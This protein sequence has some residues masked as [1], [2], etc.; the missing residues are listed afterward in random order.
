MCERFPFTV[1][2]PFRLPAEEDCLDCFFFSCLSHRKIVIKIQ[3]LLNLALGQGLA[4]IASIVSGVLIGGST[5]TLGAR[6]LQKSDLLLHQKTAN[7]SLAQS[8]NGAISNWINPKTGSSGAFRPMTT[9]TLANGLIC[10]AFR[11]TIVFSDAIQSG[12]GTACR[13][14]DGSWKIVSDDFG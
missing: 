8:E 11:T 14:R 5:G 7:Q 4:R 10:R 9:Y 2:R 13:Q 3:N 1:S 6:V 12:I